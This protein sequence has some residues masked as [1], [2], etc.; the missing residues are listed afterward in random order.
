MTQ[1]NAREALKQLLFARR[2]AMTKTQRA[3]PKKPARWLY[4]WTVE[5]HYGTAIRAYMRPIKEYVHQYI[6]EHQEMILHGDSAAVI[7]NDATT[8][9]SFTLMV[10]SLQGWAA[11]NVPPPG[12]D[13]PTTIHLGLGSIAESAFSFN[14]KQ[15]Q[16]SLKSELGV[17]F[18]VYEDWWPDAKAA[19]VD[20]NYKL[21]QSSVSEYIDKVENSTE[22]A[23]TSGWSVGQLAQQLRKIDSN[24]TDGRASFIARDQMGKLN[25]EVTHRRMESIGLSMYV[26]STS[27]DERVR[28]SHAELEGKLC[29]WDDATVYSDDGGK[30]WKDRPGSWCQLHPGED[31]QCRCTALSYFDE[32]V[33]EADQQI[34]LLSKQFSG[35]AGDEEE[36]RRV[37]NPPM[38]NTNNEMA[39]RQQEEQEQRRLEKNREKA[40]K[41]A[42]KE[43]PNEKWKQESERIYVAEKKKRDANYKVEMNMA[44][45]LESKGSTV[46]ILPEDRRSRDKKADAIVNGDYMEFKTVIGGLNSL[47]HRFLKSRSQSRNVFINIESDLSKSDVVSTLA[48]T[49]AGNKYP[50]HNNFQGGKIILRFRGGKMLYLNVDDLV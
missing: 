50:A 31:Y 5:K 14:D 26:W 40:Q 20:K 11:K 2:K 34:D 45:I 27:S 23:V 41:F 44:R 24:L 46:F 42:K 29:R 3:R 49:R 19:W 21:I 13:T 4:P 7:R 47:Q 9:R 10:K 39:K 18:P 22:Q 8:G 17:E 16:K 35:Y 1:Q 33:N 43:F 6:K 32:L 30:T 12:S 36:A 25:G 15:F 48:G 37:M 28:D 38:A